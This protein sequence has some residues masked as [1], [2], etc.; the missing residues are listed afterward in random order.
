MPTDLY[1]ELGVSRGASAD[2]IKK[3]YRKLAAKLHPDKNP[4]NAQAEARFKAVNRAH[5][6]LSDPKKRALYDEFG[7]DALRESFDAEAARAYRRAR[8]GGGANPFGGRGGFDFSDIFSGRG[9]GVGSM[10][11]ILGE[12]F[13]GGKRRRAPAKGSDVASEITVDFVS[14]IRG[15]TLELRVQDGGE[16]VSV[17]I[18]P[19]AGD[20][21]KLRVGGQGAPGSF[22]G[23]PGDLI[24]VIRVKPH[25]YFERVGLDL[26][27]DLP[28]SVS[29]AYGGAK[30]VVPTPN[31]NVTLTIP[32]RAQSGQVVRLRGR[33][34]KR[35][36]SQGDMYVR[37]NIRLP[38]AE[39]D[40]IREAIDTLAE[41][42]DP[43]LRAGIEF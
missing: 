11:D 3:A 42:T 13:G 22:G 40:E 33:G 7:E 26:Y 28:I 30:V 12:M 14:A 20:G 38:E 41:A 16:E 10:G 17:R 31:G 32:K 21:D 5:Q 24:L 27:L 15:A 2:E 29:E 19:G 8:A 39:S 35:Q 18:P 34:V 37:F 6:V 43:H 4:G 36:K 23:P 1:Q 9:G 25:P